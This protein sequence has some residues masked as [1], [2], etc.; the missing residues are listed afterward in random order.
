[1]VSMI[2][3][4]VEMN[5]RTEQAKEKFKAE[6]IKYAIEQIHQTAD[7]GED[8]IYFYKDTLLFDE[9]NNM[10]SDYLFNNIKDFLL[11][12]KYIIEENPNFIKI[13]WKSM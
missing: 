3:S 13:S 12:Y 1:M 11:P 5:S 9:D 2:E 7:R 4:A 10:I 6:A 8:C